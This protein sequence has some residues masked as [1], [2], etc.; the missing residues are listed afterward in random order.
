MFGCI[1]LPIWKSPPVARKLI[2]NPV[3]GDWLDPLR[4]LDHHW[5]TAR[6]G[7]SRPRTVSHVIGWTPCKSGTT[8][9]ALRVARVARKHFDYNFFAPKELRKN[10]FL[11]CGG[12][13]CSVI[14]IGLLARWTW[15]GLGA[16]DGLGLISSIFLD[17]GS[18]GNTRQVR[19]GLSRHLGQSSFAFY[20]F[21]SMLVSCSAAILAIVF[22]DMQSSHGSRKT[23]EALG[24]IPRGQF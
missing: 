23:T 10:V 6:G 1:N 12:L 7:E 19:S 3:A 16:S 9:R 21:F 15:A 11:H 2:R 14:C 24:K 20:Q 4:E 5:G 22:I 18:L 13:L 17:F 8:P